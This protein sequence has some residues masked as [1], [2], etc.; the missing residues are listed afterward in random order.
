MKSTTE[1]EARTIINKH[2]E[3]MIDELNA[4]DDLGYWPT[5]CGAFTDVVVAVLKHQQRI[6]EYHKSEQTD[7]T[8]AAS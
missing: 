4:V 8:R 1:T 2:M 7:F 6:D 5:D 3:S